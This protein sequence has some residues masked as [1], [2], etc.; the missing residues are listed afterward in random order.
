M[1]QWFSVF[2]YQWLFQTIKEVYLDKC[3]LVL[4]M[5][6]KQILK[7]QAIKADAVSVAVVMKL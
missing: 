4:S 2:L 5:S 3:I 6:F 7:L 1:I